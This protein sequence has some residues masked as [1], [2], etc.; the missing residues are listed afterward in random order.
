MTTAVTQVIDLVVG[1]CAESEDAP[2]SVS[3]EE[4]EKQLVTR[5]AALNKSFR[6]PSLCVLYGRTAVKELPA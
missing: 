1:H 2:D 6:W 4:S 5:K 3:E